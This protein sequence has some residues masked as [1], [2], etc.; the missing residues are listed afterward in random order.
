MNLPAE[1]SGSDQQNGLRGIP[2][3]ASKRR[4]LV[5]P[6]V[7]AVVALSLGAAACGG[8]DDDS[9]SDSASTLTAADVQNASGSID[10]VGWQFYEDEAAQ[11]AGAV[12][13][14]WSYIATDN[15]IITGA[16]SAD[17]D[18]LNS[19]GPQMPPL[20]ALGT[21]APIDTGLLSNYEAITSK[22]RDDSLWQNDDGQVVA[23]PMGVAPIFL[24]Y[25]SAEVPE[26]K[27]VEDLL[28]PAYK[29]SIALFDAPEIIG[30]IALSQGVEDTTKMTQDELDEAMSFLEQLKPNVKTFNQI[31]EDAQL[32]AR[33]DIKVS[34]SS[35][36]AGL[37]AIVEENPDI[38]FNFTGQTTFIDAWSILG[39]PNNA[40][41]LNW[42]DQT[43]SKEGQE[44]IVNVSG[45]YPVNSAALPALE[46]I[47]D[48][49]S[50]TLS[51]MT[52]DE[53]L[54]A[55]PPSQGFAAE[56]GDDDVVTLDEATRAWNEYKASF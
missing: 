4:R 31:G 19:S 55:A 41:A 26:P 42:I 34:F 54:D 15:D 2:K 35:F 40:A 11:D 53:I 21:L 37:G 50:K 20:N 25:N 44:A 56:S 12:K 32:F 45:D 1:R 22:L 51:G 24:A 49:V 17:A 29:S 48:P 47:G 9:S 16:R 5:A 10:V 14:E 6:A 33:G 46:A 43:L 28:D 18:V 27:T 23:V 38:K 3:R 8:D 36:G 39:D 30:K 52:L 13:S 7:L